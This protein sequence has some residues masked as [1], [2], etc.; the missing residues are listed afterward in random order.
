MHS[1]IAAPLC[2]SLLVPT[3]LVE[4]TI[5]DMQNET[6]YDRPRE[7]GLA[8]FPYWH[9]SK[10]S[11]CICIITSIESR[12]HQIRGMAEMFYTASLRSFEKA[13][14][15]IVGLALV[16]ISGSSSAPKKNELC[17]IGKTCKNSNETYCGNL[18]YLALKP[19]RS[20]CDNLLSFHLS[21]HDHF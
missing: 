1:V 2:R 12:M 3:C 18:G 16:Y 9:M 4:I 13:C 19:N 14:I 17:H 6:I 10:I 21:S 7:A 5:Y 8:A 20:G 15:Y 11:Q